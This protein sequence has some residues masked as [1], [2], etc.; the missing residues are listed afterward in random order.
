MTRDQF[1]KALADSDSIITYRSTNSNKLKYNVC[2]M[3]FNCEYIK[4]K[5]YRAKVPEDSVL[6]F[7]W[8][9]DSYRL[10]KPSRVVSVVPLEKVL[11]GK[12]NL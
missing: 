8:D 10:M 3:D 2:T 7:C 6:L 9:T 5:Q 4:S 12:P 1:I 11:N